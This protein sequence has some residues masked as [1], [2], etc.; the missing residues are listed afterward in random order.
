MLNSNKGQA[1]ILLTILITS[2]ILLI[3][4]ATSV[5]VIAE[6][7]L[8]RNIGDSVIAFYAADAGAERCLYG[9]NK[10]PDDSACG[11]VHGD[12]QLFTGTL[13]N[14]AKYI[15]DYKT[16]DSFTSTGEAPISLIRRKVEL[17][18]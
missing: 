11:E 10:N 18:F 6:I 8:S 7:K 3:I 5:I 1:A 15:L 12:G 16:A 9:I 14:G 2:V 4:L 17:T 13:D